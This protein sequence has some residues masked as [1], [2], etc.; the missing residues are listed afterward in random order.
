M[1]LLILRASAALS[2]LLALA[3]LVLIIARGAHLLLP[4]V[5]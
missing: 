3:A 5:S 1:R 4:L 2:Y